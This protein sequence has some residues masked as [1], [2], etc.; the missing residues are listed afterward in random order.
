[1]SRKEYVM[2]SYV[3]IYYSGGDMGD[4]PM[5]EIKATWM[6][7]FEKLGDKL[8]DAGNPFNDG[9]QAVEKSGVTT[10]ENFPASGYSIV[11]ANSMNEAVELA[12]NCPILQSSATAVR[13]Y[14]TM[15]M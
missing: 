9:G 12:K 5:E 1:M 13:V 4:M 3:F 15:P 7:W 2:K 6:A 14:E 8:V 10:I 11:K